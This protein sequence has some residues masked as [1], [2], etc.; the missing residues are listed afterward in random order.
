MLQAEVPLVPIDLLLESTRVLATPN[1]LL[2]LRKLQ[3]L[4]GE[5]SFA[6]LMGAIVSCSSY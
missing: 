2:E 4:Q 1:P 6:L 3:D 5:S